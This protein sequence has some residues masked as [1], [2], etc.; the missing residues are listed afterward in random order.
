MHIEPAKSPSDAWVVNTG[1]SGDF[2]VKAKGPAML[3]GEKAIKARILTLKNLTDKSKSKAEWPAGSATLKWPSKVNLTDG[4]RY[5]LRMKGS[6]TV[7][8]I[9][10]HLVSRRPAVG[11]PPGRVDGP[12]RVRKTGHAAARRAPLIGPQLGRNRPWIQPIG[13]RHPVHCYGLGFL[14][15]SATESV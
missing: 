12:E 14:P 9:K 13:L 2:C 6:R 15:L 5:L 10:L 7:R 11:C 3:W 1:K 8:K 4:A